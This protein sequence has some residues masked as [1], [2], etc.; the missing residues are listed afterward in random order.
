MHIVRATD[1]NYNVYKFI[2]YDKSFFASQIMTLSV[3]LNLRRGQRET[4]QY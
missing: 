3:L 1:T 4:A 2:Y